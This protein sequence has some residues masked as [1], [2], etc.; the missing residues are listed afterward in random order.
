MKRPPLDVYL[1]NLARMAAT[2][3]TC[4]KRSVGAVLADS[5]RVV[6]TG[7]NGAPPGMDHCGHAL[8]SKREGKC[9][10]TIHAEVNAV[11]QAK[12]SFA[13]TMY[14]TDQPCLGCTKVLLA[15]TPAIQVYYVRPSSDQDRDDFLKDHGIEGQFVQLSNETIE[16]MLSFLPLMPGE[17]KLL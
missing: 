12:G 8:C 14:C 2:R 4:P 3:A 10:N 9:I 1:M 7:Y 13:Q 11:I 17:K 15:F 6:S 5:G 16:E